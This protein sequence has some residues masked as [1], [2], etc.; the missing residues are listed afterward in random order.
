MRIYSHFEGHFFLLKWLHTY[1]VQNKLTI[2]F[3]FLEEE[4]CSFLNVYLLKANLVYEH[5]A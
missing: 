1:N 3:G 2:L 5:W 4:I